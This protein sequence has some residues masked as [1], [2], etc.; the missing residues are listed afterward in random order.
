M[1]TTPTSP[2]TRWRATGAVALV[3]LSLALAACGSSG[4]ATSSTGG[5]A[6]AAPRPYGGSPATTSAA[7]TSTPAKTSTPAAAS[8]GIP[9]GPTAGDRDSDN[10]GGP[11]DG[12]GNI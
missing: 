11:S 10:N 7:T 9:Q 5:A 6:S 3:A 4:S 2:S 1:S 8:S 12:D